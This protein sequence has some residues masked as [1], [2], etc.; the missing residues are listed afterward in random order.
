MKLSIVIP[1]KNESKR[2]ITPLVKLYTTLASYYSKDEFEIIVA[3]NNTSDNSFFRLQRLQ[4]NQNL[5]AL[6]VIN[7]GKTKGKGEAV[8]KAFS[9]A[10]GDIIGFIDADGSS[11]PVDVLKM[12][13][14]LETESTTDAIISSRYM[15]NSLI[16]G[17]IPFSRKVLS[18]IFNKTVQLFFGTK[19]EDTQ[20]GLKLFKASAIKQVIPYVKAYGWAFDVNILSVLGFMGYK[21]REIPSTW[22]AKKGSTLK[23]FSTIFSVA[24]DFLNI[25]KVMWSIRA[26]SIKSTVANRLFPKSIVS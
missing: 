11:A 17:N 15:S 21:T 2:I 4:E 23:I 13:R 26:E 18:L 7:L 9:Y 22:I 10:T 5:S 16:V 24:S 14:I 25:S 8:I 3:I 1:A 19:F 20:C 6:R 12:A